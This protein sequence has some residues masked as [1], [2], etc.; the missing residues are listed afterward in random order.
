MIN[1]EGLSIFR[2]NKD[3]IIIKAL[4]IYAFPIVTQ[5]KLL[6]ILIQL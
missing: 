6:E 4:R 3:I 5:K 1:K 2:F